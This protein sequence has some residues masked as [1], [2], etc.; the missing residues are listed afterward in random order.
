MLGRRTIRILMTCSGAMTL[1]VSGLHGQRPSA[2]GLL[3]PVHFDLEAVADSTEYLIYRYRII[4]PFVSRGGVAGIRLDLSAPAG[5]GRIRLPFTGELGHGGGGPADHVPVGGIGPEHWWMQVLYNALFDWYAADV[6]VVVNDSGVS[7]SA[8]SAAPGTAKEGFGLR[9]PYLPGVR[10]FSADPTYQSCC[11]KPI[12]D[13]EEHE[14][15]SPSDFRVHGFTVAPTVRPQDMSLDI[16]ASDLRQ[17]CG[18]LHWIS[19]QSVC[20]SLRTNLDQAAAAFRQHDH[21]GLVTA[22]SAF[23]DQLEQRHGVSGPVNDN[24]YWLLKV[25]G[26]YLR[27][28]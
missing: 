20:R 21:A 5:T 24:A 23:L 10:R 19:D 25:N 18:N 1:T 4:N 9:S 22:L 8:D 15:P 2:Q 27:A 7:A 12:P 13:T 28:H 17:V 11:S 26:E 3:G 6:G 16:L 14:Y